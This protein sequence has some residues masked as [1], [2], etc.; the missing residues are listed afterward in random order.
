MRIHKTRCAA[1]LLLL[2]LAGQASAEEAAMNLTLKEAVR[3]AVERNLDV[4][5]ELYNPA[6][7]EADIRK[8]HGIYDTL[9]SLNASYQNSTTLPAST[10][11]AGAATSKQ[12]AYKLNPGVSQLVPTGGTVGLVF[13]NTYNT[14]NSDSS[15]GFMN[16]YWQ[17]DLTLTL[18]QPLLQN[19][20]QD[21]TELNINVARY[22]KEGALEQFKNKLVDV[23]SQVRNQYFQLHSLRE[24]LEVKKTSLALAQK[25]LDN[26]TAQ[27]KAGVLPAMEILNAEFGVATRQKDLIDAERLLKDQTDALRLFIQIQ[28]KGDIQPV[29]TLS[30]EH[31]QVDEAAEVQHALAD[32]PDL[33][34]LMVTVKSNELQARVARNQTLPSLNLTASAAFT[35]LSADYNRDLERVGSG[36]Y[37][38]WGA[39]LQFA[40]PLGNNAAENTYIKSRLKVEQSQTQAKSLAEN[41]ANDVRSAVR[42]IDA[43]YKQLEVT[44]RGSAYAEERLKAFIKKNQVGLATTK[45][46]LDVENDRVTAKGSEIKALSDYNNAITQLWKATGALLDREGI[47]LTEKEAD[48]LYRKTQ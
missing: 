9:L 28:E 40:Y 21:A 7:S 36:S 5:A 47:K 19:F 15:R 1:V 26:T 23:V 13:D 24:N 48:A 25:I 22:A 39:G 18:S 32:R 11:L 4:K 37:P 29:D 30:S 43:S 42:A 44:R 45:D 34:Q 27:V 31:Y 12:E 17:S 6:L 10:F 38:V 8:N 46:V 3:M 33:K 20:G 14:N 16:K 35:G 2:A 41:I